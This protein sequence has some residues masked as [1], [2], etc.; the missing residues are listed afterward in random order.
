MPI[1]NVKLSIM[2]TVTR[3]FAIVVLAQSVS[4]LWIVAQDRPQYVSIIQL[5]SNPT[6]YDGKLIQVNGFLTFDEEGSAIYLHEEDYRR[7][8]LK[9]GIWLSMD[10]RQ[11]LDHKYAF[12]EG[13]FNARDSGHGGVFSGSIE[14]VTRSNSIKIPRSRGLIWPAPQGSADRPPKRPDPAK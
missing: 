9:N 5:I 6:V 14:K 8:L 1:L 4:P 13:V 7:G 12:I 11:D 2:K 10:A 3:F